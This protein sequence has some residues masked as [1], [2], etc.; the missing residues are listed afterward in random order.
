[1]LK[2]VGPAPWFVCL[3]LACAR[4]AAPLCEG[5]VCDLGFECAPNTGLC[6]RSPQDAGSACQSDDEC[7]GTTPHCVVGYCVQCGADED[8]QTGRCDRTTGHCLALPDSCLTVGTP[9]SIPADGL[10]VSGD[11]SKGRDDTRLSCALPTSVGKDLVYNILV[12]E[13]RR[14]SAVVR[15]VAPGALWP[16]LELRRACEATG[17][18]STISCS[19]GSAISSSAA[20][21][22]DSLEAGTY[23]L[24]VDG[25]SDTEGEFSL[26]LHLDPSTTSG[27]CRQPTPLN[28]EAAPAVTAWNPVGHGDEQKSSCGGAG[29]PDAVYAF[30][31]T[32]PRRVKA[33][34]TPAGTAFAPVAYLRKAACD[35][36]TAAQVACSKGSAYGPAEL[37]V[38]RLEPGTY[39]LVIDSVPLTAPSL[40]VAMSLDV[41]ALPPVP[42]PTN[43][44]CANAQVLALPDA[45]V[46]T[47]TV[48]G[49]TTLAHADATSC[50]GTGNDLVYTFDLPGDR[51][52]SAT[53]TPLAGST[54]RPA[55]YVRPKSGCSSE[56]P[57]DQ[58][59]C[60]NAGEPGKPAA[61][62]VPSLR[63]GS[64][65][66]WV[67]GVAGSVGPFELALNVAASPA[68][69]VNDAC[70]SATPISL[71]AGAVTVSGT[72][73]AARDD[74][75][76]CQLP[77]GA[78]SPD[79][80]YSFDVASPISLAI[81]AKTLPGSQ[82]RPVITV[83]KPGA[84]SSGA[85]A[86]EITCAFTDNQYLDRVVRIIPRLAV[87]TH[88]LW[89]DGD[90]S[91]QGAFS[92]RLTPGP[93][94]A[95]PTNDACGDLGVPTLTLGAAVPGDTRGAANDLTAQ[96]NLASTLMGE[97]AP[98]VV[99]RVTLATT[100]TLTV[101]VTPDA[102]DG[103]LFRP[104]VVVREKGASG[105][106]LA[107][108]NKGCQ[109]APAYGAPVTLTLP[110][111]PAGSYS[112]IVDGAAV[113][114]GRFTV[115][116]Q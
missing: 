65:A 32:Q 93:A 34:L 112:I 85:M 76:S 75:S 74:A 77:T 24:W 89:V 83:R 104:V 106:L 111:L 2:K 90:L 87:G 49:D 67:D 73:T 58:L 50:K 56:M 14:F 45:G 98:D 91:T 47:L 61:L 103:T 28:I 68:P 19:A 29:G 12:P 39:Y 44:T 5:V 81:D 36:S 108:S 109:V 92:L 51:A 82:L 16:V 6:A 26:E 79:V 86:D 114:S 48:T 95:A 22:I 55:V 71:A 8:C 88:F 43:D 41:R 10:T 52:V 18:A 31:L 25:E 33:E 1:M 21:V 115:L 23:S 46:G 11:T 64:W 9:L 20:L 17:P 113:S 35:G 62:V 100:R 40:S 15:G 27:T 60:V 38:P 59:A 107:A 54:L 3:A 94:I 96:C 4:T 101:T 30:T 78:Y 53:V 7:G 110:S 70:A 66:L 116:A 105:C 37:D 13:P 57:P 97:A 99:Y 63:A 84:C 69:P 102:A 42:E 72:T 80:V